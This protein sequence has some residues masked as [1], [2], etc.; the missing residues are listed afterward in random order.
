MC[1]ILLRGRGRGRG[2][3]MPSNYWEGGARGAASLAG[4]KSRPNVAR[5]AS[6]NGGEEM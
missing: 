3:M 1:T 5:V 2:D 4:G 6:L